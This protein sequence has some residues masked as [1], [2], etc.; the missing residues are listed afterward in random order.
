M[1]SPAGSIDDLI[2]ELARARG[3]GPT[4][5]LATNVGATLAAFG[6]LANAAG[7]IFRGQVF[8]D[9]LEPISNEAG[10]LL[11]DAGLVRS[12][13]DGIVVFHERIG[14]NK[15]AL[16]RVLAAADRASGRLS[17]TSRSQPQRAYAQAVKA[18]L[19]VRDKKTGRIVRLTPAGKR[20]VRRVTRKAVLARQAKTNKRQKTALAKLKGIGGK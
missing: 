4:S 19:V 2:K 8:Q 10:R 7:D 14:R 1:V 12:V 15:P 9:G 17:K 11:F 20:E 13:D 5:S 18:G 6:D 3:A 16:R